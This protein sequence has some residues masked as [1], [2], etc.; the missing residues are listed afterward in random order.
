MSC[1]PDF[2]ANQ[3]GGWFQGVTYPPF[4]TTAR[5]LLGHNNGLHRTPMFSL[6][7]CLSLF[8]P[9][10]TRERGGGISLLLRDWVVDQR[11]PGGRLVIKPQA[12]KRLEK[13]FGGV[14]NSPLPRTALTTHICRRG[15][16]PETY[17][18][19]SYRIPSRAESQ[20]SSCHDQ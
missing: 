16:I 12:Q 4:P 11:G 8:A 10:S 9:V 15:G 14:G 18:V 17:S 7:I 19:E 13:Y 20:L 6:L 3:P 2:A 1:I 5:Q